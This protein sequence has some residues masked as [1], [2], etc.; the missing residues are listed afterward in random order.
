[1]KL[2]SPIAPSF[3]IFF[4]FLSI[5]LL[6]S[7]G[8]LY[9]QDGLIIYKVAQNLFENG[10]WNI[11]GL[12]PQGLSLGPDGQ[13]YSPYGL[14]TSLAYIPLIALGHAL[15]HVPNLAGVK[16]ALAMSLNCFVTAFS[17]IF[18]YLC[19]R[20]LRFKEK[21]SISLT[22]FYGLGSFVWPYAKFGFPDP[23]S[24]LFT[25]GAVFF[26][27][28]YPSKQSRIQLFWCGFFMGC[29]C[30][31]RLTTALFVPAIILYLLLKELSHSSSKSPRSI[32]LNTL[33]ILL[34]A[35]LPLGLIA[36]YNTERFGSWLLTGY[37][38]YII[39]PDQLQRWGFTTPLFVGLY[40]LL[41]SAGKSIFLY[42]PLALLVYPALKKFWGTNKHECLLFIIMIL[43][44]FLFFSCWVN[45]EGGT[46]WGPRYLYPIIFCLILPI[47]KL[48][49]S[50]RKWRRL[51]WGLFMLGFFINSLGVLISFTEYV[52]YV[53]KEWD[54]YGLLLF[55]P[56][57]SPIYGHL[58]LCFQKL[59]EV[60]SHFDLGLLK[61]FRQGNPWAGKAILFLIFMILICAFFLRRR[62]KQE[63]RSKG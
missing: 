42:V 15:S 6:S 5:F 2:T 60:N 8:H 57:F 21:T 25:L 47:G 44:M 61:S 54:R 16:T 53:L 10:R 26:A 1:M 4:F 33:I 29:M 39:G 41:F 31:T 22:L 43:Q 38:A 45:W 49:E 28:S 23:L 3:F 37:H 20:A 36:Y 35:I 55:H 19:A 18:F 40:G 59:F 13:L 34:G 12:P 63:K 48:M 58:E 7:G 32:F 24:G 52:G 11:T 17:C 14:G 56:G 27:V 51:C 62:A 50:S 9:T 46:S 30:L